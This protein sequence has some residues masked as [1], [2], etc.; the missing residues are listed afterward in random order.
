[1]V[2]CDPHKAMHVGV[3]LESQNSRASTEFKRGVMS[4]V[5][6]RHGHSLHYSRRLTVWSTCNILASLKDIIDKHTSKLRIFQL[7]T[8]TKQSTSSCLAFLIFCCSFSLSHMC[9][10][11]SF[12]VKFLPMSRL[13]ILSPS[14]LCLP[15]LSLF[16]VP[17]CLELH[18]QSLL[19][20]LFFR[21]FISAFPLQKYNALKVVRLLILLRSYKFGLKGRQQ[22]VQTAAIHLHL[23]AGRQTCTRGNLVK[24]FVPWCNGSPSICILYSKRDGYTCRNLHR[25]G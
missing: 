25:L 10:S 12:Y 15:F 13:S 1:M 11:L 7:Y 21:P 8:D 9:F 14:L 5:E 3:T 4:D 23:P 19:P 18:A 16:P 22:K 24:S 17:L 2:K 6:W 20:T